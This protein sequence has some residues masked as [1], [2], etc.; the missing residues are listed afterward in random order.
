MK[1]KEI[2]IVE[3][4]SDKQFLQTFLDADIFTCNGSAIDGFDFA[5]IEKLSK[6]RGV[7]I[8]TDPDYPG[9]KIRNFLQDK[10]KNCKHAFVRKEKS[11]KHRKVGVAESSKEEVLH[12]IENIVSFDEN[13]IK[14]ILTIN[15]LVQLKLT[16]DNSINNKKKII[17][18]YHIGYCNSKTMLKRLNMLNISFEEL[19]GVLF[20]D[21]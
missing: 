15:D 10:I 12:A 3:G 9:M 17:D 20:D 7:I 16:G 19:K 14:G 2:I 4:K 21:Q 5:Y 11:I 8:L 13:D 18:M 1:I 6:E